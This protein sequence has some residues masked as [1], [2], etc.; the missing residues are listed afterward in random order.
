MRVV[1]VIIA[2][3]VVIFA[4]ILIMRSGEQPG[5]QKKIV[6]KVEQESADLFVPEL[7]RV[8]IDP[9]APISTDF[10][11]AVPVLKNPR[12]KF[13]KYTYQWYV[14]GS[15]VADSDKKLLPKGNYKKGDSVACRVQAVRGQYKSGEVK[16][17]SVDVGNAPPE[18]QSQAVPSFQVPG[19]FRYKIKAKDPDGDVLSYRLL[20]PQDLDIA[21]D[22]DTGEIQWYI[23][24]VPKDIPESKPLSPSDEGSGASTPKSTDNEQ[25]QKLSPVVQIVFEIQDSEGAAVT[26]GIS[27]N[28][29]TGREIAY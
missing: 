4:A 15:E 7:E 16:S 11:R 18:I 27:L 13:V 5:E 22:P 25:Q 14:N 29:S 23:D 10:I 6:P 1:L 2:V 19:E 24:S 26:G 9:P 21:L 17:S 12:L 20:S 28:L 8:D 3:L